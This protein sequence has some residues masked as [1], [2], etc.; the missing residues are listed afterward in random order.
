MQAFDRGWIY[1]ATNDIKMK[2]RILLVIAFLLVAGGASAPEKRSFKRFENDFQLGSG[3]F[4]ESGYRSNEQNPGL[5]IR[6]SYG[7]DLRF[8]EEWSMMPEVGYRTG[9]G[10]YAHRSWA[11]NDPDYLDCY[12]FSLTARYHMK[13]DANHYVLGLGPAFSY[14][15]TSDTYYFDA[16]PSHPLAG[17]EKFNKY[18][19]GLKPSVS[20]LVGKH[21]QVGL[22]ANIGLLNM[23]RQYPEYNKT[24]STHLH[25]LAVTCGVHF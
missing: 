9:M 18:D 2:K 14:V 25:Y 19:I 6:L 17:K 11:G 8:N 10:D 4:L 1:D 5:V 15:S 16:D 12:D 21:F 22:E 24:G 20:Y 13:T 7:L 23:R 3:L